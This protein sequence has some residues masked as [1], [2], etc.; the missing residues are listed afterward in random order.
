MAIP[1]AIP[2]P[3]NTDFT[4][5]SF[6]VP[7]TKRP[8]Q[9][10]H[11]R[12][13]F[14][15]FVDINTPGVFTTLPEVFDAG[16]SIAKDKSF[17][18]HRPVLSKNPLTHARHYVWQ[19]YAEVDERRRH[20]GSAVHKLFENG[21]VGGGEYPTVGLWS[22]NRP[23]WVLIDLALNAYG[24]VG[25][26]LYDTFGDQTPFSIDHAHLTLIF[27]SS[28]H[29]TTL[30][31]AAPRHPHLKLIVVI[32]ELE[33]ETKRFA[34]AWSQTQGVKLQELSELEEFGKKYRCNVIIP[35]AN[36]IATICYTS[37][38]T[39]S[40]VLLTHG[41]LAVAT[42]S[43]LYGYSIGADERVTL[44]SYLPLAHIYERINQTVVIALGGAIGFFTG[45]PLRLLEDAQILKPNY[46]PSVPRVLNRIYQAATVAGNVPGL[47]GAIF[48]RAVQAKLDNLRATGAITHPLWDR[49]VFKKIQAVLGGN[50]KLVVSGS[51]PISAEVLD[52]LRIALSCRILEGETFRLSCDSTSGGTV[53]PPQPA[54]ELKLVDVPSMNYTA[55][56]R[57]FPRGEICCRGSCNFIQYYKEVDEKNTKEAVDAEGWIHTGDIGEIDDHGRFRIIDRVKNIMKLSQGEYVALEKIENIYSRIPAVMQVFVHGDS[58]KSYLVGVIVP[59]PVAF[60]A[61]ASRILKRTVDAADTQAMNEF[62][63]DPRIV[64][65]LLKELNAVTANGL[66]GFEQLKRIHLSLDP[67]SV[68]ENTLT[69]TLKMRRRDAYNKYKTALDALYELPDPPHSESASS[70]L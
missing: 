43:N 38:C 31:K 21:T 16:Y 37:I 54:A 51:A 22:L 9:T 30:L 56:D 36:D 62:C 14:F 66:K 55:E 68:A 20:I 42:Q 3:D 64:D 59:D 2:L 32:D 47:K 40:G 60:A 41:S 69:P 33:P 11:Y 50:I 25:V 65:S 39:P 12:N 29:L 35:S 17:L 7:G 10:A 46:F 70:K 1:G 8:G 45:D 5:Q 49:L 15:G 18:G 24:K 26:S 67:F 28:D 13:A 61:F 19:T 58:L 23:E 27:T 57:P 6:Q 34:A 48:R 4:R 52:F 63:G 44:L 53:G